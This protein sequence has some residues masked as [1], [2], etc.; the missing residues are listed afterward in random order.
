MACVTMLAPSLAMA[1]TQL[2]REAVREVSPVHSETNSERH[3]LRLNWVVVTGSN[4][5]LLCSYWTTEDLCRL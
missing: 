5:Y 2:V 3:S 4:G 1:T